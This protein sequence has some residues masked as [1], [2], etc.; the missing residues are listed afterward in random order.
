MNIENLMTKLAE[1][2]SRIDYPVNEVISSA[3]QTEL[4]TLYLKLKDLGKDSRYTN[5][6]NIQDLNKEI[7]RYNSVMADVDKYT[8]STVTPGSDKPGMPEVPRQPMPGGKTKPGGDKPLAGNQFAIMKMQKDLKAAG[9]DLGTYGSNKDGV[10]GNLG[11]PNSKTRQAMKKYPDIA[12]KHGFDPSGQG[13]MTS[14]NAQA[15]TSTTTSTT[16]MNDQAIAGMLYKS[17]SGIGTDSTQFFNAIKQIKT[18][19]QFANVSKLYRTVAGE[20]LMAAI[21]G[22]FSGTDLGNIQRM[23]SKFQPK[24]ESSELDKI[25]FLSGIK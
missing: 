5:Y 16:P 11:G 23:L 6:P 7:D 10:D 13:A 3:E 21:E 18:P 24:K 2:E 14:P 19:Q 20:D 1:I 4:N 22:D 9:A 25:K 17:M 12:K 15:T 8:T